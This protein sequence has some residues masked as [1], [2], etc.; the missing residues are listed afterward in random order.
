MT[1]KCRGVVIEVHPLFICLLLMVA[2]V[3]GV[4]QM[5][6]F[7]L[8]L[9]V[10]ELGHL[11]V[12]AGQGVQVGRLQF[13]PF[14]SVIHPL[15]FNPDP[16]SELL[17]CAGGPLSSLALMAGAWLLGDWFPNPDLTLFL[18][19]FNATLGLV[20]LLPLLP[21]DGG[22]MLRAHWALTVG[23]RRANAR[24]IQLGR[25][26]A[27]GLAAGG[28]LLLA[29]GQLLPSWFLL[30]W[31]LMRSVME[32]RD[33]GTYTFF[34]HWAQKHDHLHRR[35]YMVS[36]PLVASADARALDVIRQFLP[37]RYHLIAVLDRGRPLGWVTEEELLQALQERPGILMRDLLIHHG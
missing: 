23:W 13:L 26:G 29:R 11:V 24:A 19:Q 32:E 14:G 3:E 21:L 7:L 10:H 15:G 22:R 6:L 31:V 35:G 4:P 18:V 16:Q 20:N 17:V 33:M 1:C 36:V 34:R 2:V 28:L 12:L 27:V 5:V 8:S 25:W 9:A 30:A 37:H